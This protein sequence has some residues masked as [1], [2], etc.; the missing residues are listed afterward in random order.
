MAVE[1]RLA[2]EARLGVSLPMLSL[3]QQTSLAMIASNLARGL[4]TQSDTAPEILLAAQRYETADPDA[5][6]ETPK[7]V[8]ASGAGAAA[9]S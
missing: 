3:S 8:E 6:R 4:A 9:G 7:P 5:I 2:L 1:L